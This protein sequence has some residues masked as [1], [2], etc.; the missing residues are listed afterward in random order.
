[1]KNMILNILYK[2]KAIDIKIINIG[3]SN[4]LA[5]YIIIVS[6]NSSTHTKSIFKNFK[7]E[8]KNNG[9]YKNSF[10]SGKNTDW[11]IIDI[12]D[13]IIHIMTKNLRS[14]YNLEE[15]IENYEN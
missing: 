12:N 9:L 11:N 1:M 15:L 10:Y 8:L 6:G 5:S 7:K 13:V 14:Y 2:Y 3:K 4:I